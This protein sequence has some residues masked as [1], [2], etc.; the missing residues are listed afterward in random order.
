MRDSFS[1][2]H[3]A[4][5]AIDLSK[6]PSLTGC[7]DAC[8]S[9]FFAS[10]LTVFESEYVAMVGRKSCW[11]GVLVVWYWSCGTG[12]VMWSVLSCVIRVDTIPEISFTANVVICG[13]SFPSHADPNSPN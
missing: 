8:V 4:S 6:V 11:F 7:V 5:M 9:M 2:K 13:C 3:P 10:F 12:R 1:V